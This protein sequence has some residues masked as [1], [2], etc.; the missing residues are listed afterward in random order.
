[1]GASRK[2]EEPDPRKVYPPAMR[3]SYPIEEVDGLFVFDEE[4]KTYSYKGEGFPDILLEDLDGWP[5]EYQKARSYVT[6]KYGDRPFAVGTVY[7]G[8][9]KHRRVSL[10]LKMALAIAFTVSGLLVALVVLLFGG[11]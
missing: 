9:R 1:M 7:S 3:R 8:K 4:L 11:R 6:E 10:A 5:E 2:S